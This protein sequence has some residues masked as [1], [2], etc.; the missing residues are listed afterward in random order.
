MS[1][2]AKGFKIRHKN[3]LYRTATSDQNPIFEHCP[4]ST[5]QFPV[6]RS[7]QQIARLRSLQSPRSHTA[8][9]PIPGFTPQSALPT[10]R[11]GH[12]NSALTPPPYGTGAAAVRRGGG[13]IFGRA[14]CADVPLHDEGISSS[15]TRPG[16]P[17]GGGTAGTAGGLRDEDCPRDSETELTGGDGGR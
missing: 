12:S 16:G 10:A 7:L 5:Q 11:G 13:V 6:A 15:T 9:H 2:Q 3:E 8:H 4:L 17:W 1:F 14:S